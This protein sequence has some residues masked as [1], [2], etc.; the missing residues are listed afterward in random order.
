MNGILD[1]ESG[2][3]LVEERCSTSDSFGIGGT[4]LSQTMGI[5]VNEIGR[6]FASYNESKSIHFQSRYGH[7]DVYS[8]NQH[9]TM[10]H[11]S[12]ARMEIT[13]LGGKNVTFNSGDSSFHSLN[14]NAGGGIVNPYDLRTTSG[15]LGLTFTGSDL[16]LGS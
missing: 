2:S 13:T 15:P 8:I 3:L 4:G 11:A 10:P 7:L 12:T 6:I 14:I 16:I 9:D 1:V 5:D